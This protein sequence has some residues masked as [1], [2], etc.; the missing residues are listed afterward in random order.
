MIT[1]GCRVQVP[2]GKAAVV[3]MRPV[4]RELK[5]CRGKGAVQYHES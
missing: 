1:V 3:L 4:L 2:F 5:A